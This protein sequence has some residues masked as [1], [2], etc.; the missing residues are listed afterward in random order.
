MCDM[1]K[2]GALFMLQQL[3]LPRPA[4]AGTVNSG[5]ADKNG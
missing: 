2:A 5:K 4:F 3:P 1:H